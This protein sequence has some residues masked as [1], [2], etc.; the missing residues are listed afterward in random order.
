MKKNIFMIMGYAM[1]LSISS[2]TY[3]AEGPYVSGNLGI[4]TPSNSYLTD[5]T[6]P[7]MK[8][9]LK[10]DSD[11]ALGVA[12]GYGFANNTRIEGEIAYTKNDFDEAS[13]LGVDVDLT[14]DTSSLAFLL[15]GYYDFTNGSQF[16]TS[17]TAGLGVAKVE[18]NDFNAPGS[19]LPSASDDDTVFAYQVGLGVGY[20]VNEK[21]IVDVKYRYFGTSD[22]QF[23]TAEAE[24]SGRVVYAGTRVSF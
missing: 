17:I 15:N 16:T 22:L 20:A 2:I 12:V 18:V 10:S 24:Y 19:G 8:I 4:S 11:L 3:S 7:G 9:E 5:S 13:L 23:D 1:L 14:G 6:S 21:V